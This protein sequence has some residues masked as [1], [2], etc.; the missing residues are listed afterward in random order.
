MSDLNEM[1]SNRAEVARVISE[2]SSMHVQ[3]DDGEG[4]KLTHNEQI[5]IAKNIESEANE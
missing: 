2:A 1:F 5:E 4:N 3:Q